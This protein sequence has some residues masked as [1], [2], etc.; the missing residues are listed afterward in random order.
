LKEAGYDVPLV[1]QMRGVVAPPGVPPDV[2]EYWEDVLRRLTRT[3]AW[4]KYLEDNQFEDGFQTGP[5]FAKSLEETNRQVRQ[6]LQE[7]GIKLVR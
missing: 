2:I 4:R 1:P 3:D 5:E 6:L 7:G